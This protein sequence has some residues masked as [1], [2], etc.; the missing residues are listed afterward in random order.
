M[1]SLDKSN[2][3]TG[4][5]GI[6]KENTNLFSNE[7]FI[8]GI[9][10]NKCDNMQLCFANKKTFDF[11]KNNHINNSQLRNQG[12]IQ[13]VQSEEE[14]ELQM[15][16]RI[17]KNL[18]NTRMKRDD[19]TLSLCEQFKLTFRKFCRLESNRNHKLYNIHKLIEF[20][21]DKIENYFDYINLIENLEET[22]VLKEMLLVGHQALLLDI[23]KMQPLAIEQVTKKPRISDKPT[24]PKDNHKALISAIDEL[25]SF[26]NYENKF[27]K[28]SPIIKGNSNLLRYLLDII[29]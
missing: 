21:L 1:Q 24:I 22:K 2:S 6:N 26:S 8:G 7:R 19:L 17:F 13:N 5:T 15:K 3:I 9:T 10:E 4:K 28:E 20:S 29:K 11:I 18:A 14:S 16:F 27:L 25:L 12:S 23:M